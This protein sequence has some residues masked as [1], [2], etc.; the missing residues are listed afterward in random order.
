V[1]TTTKL[2]NAQEIS[3]AL[4]RFPAMDGSPK[5][6]AELLQSLYPESRFRFLGASD[7]DRDDGRVLTPNGTE[8]APSFNA[9][10]RAE[11]ERIGT[12]RE[13]CEIHKDKGLVKTV[14]R[15]RVYFLT[16][17]Y[18]P[19]PGDFFQVEVHQEEEFLHQELF[20]SHDWGMPKD[21]FDLQGSFYHSNVPGED[22]REPLGPPVYKLGKLTNIKTF[23]RELE[24]TRRQQRLAELPAKEKQ[25]L[26]KVIIDG[27]G[28]SE[29]E[30]T[31]FLEAFPNW[32]DDPVG[33]SRF[34]SDWAA[35]SAG[36]SDHL[37]CDHWYLGLYDYVHEG[38]RHIGFIPRWSQTDG[39]LNLPEIRSELDDNP[40][41]V[42]A[43]LEDFDC[44]T[45]YPFS[46]YFYGLHGNRVCSYT[47]NVIARAVQE[48][49]IGLPAHD[50]EVLIRWF[51][52]QY[53]F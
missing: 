34:L 52:S 9:W 30:E 31:P 21:L 50:A 17:P 12:A 46:W 26:R 6:V 23:M 40:F 44:Q 36:R 15:G 19:E 38:Q 25:I 33:E 2:F 22:A 10:V 41:S 28:G 47:L 51:D 16:S 13:V 48:G 3:E 49:R 35:S 27:Q 43:K 4:S 18:G 1:K 37:L 39:G 5:T 53:G 7:Y 45:G 11:L 24:S 29:V 42:M 32:V 14:V 8:L 20:G